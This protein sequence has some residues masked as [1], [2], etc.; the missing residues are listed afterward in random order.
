MIFAVLV[1]ALGA[2]CLLALGSGDQ[3]LPLRE[4]L[5]A[6]TGAP[7]TSPVATTIVTTLRLPR[8]H[9][10]PALAQFLERWLSIHLLIPVSALAAWA[11]NGLFAG[12]AL[13]LLFTVRT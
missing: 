13:F 9:S 12:G 4:V 8:V 2:A 3:P 11:T 6:L 7:E 1:A 5:G 10:D